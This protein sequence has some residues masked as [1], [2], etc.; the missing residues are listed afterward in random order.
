MVFFQNQY[1]CFLFGFYTQENFKKILKKLKS[2]GSKN[3][4]SSN[5]QLKHPKLF[6]VLLS[7]VVEHK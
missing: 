1:A 5:V 3:G 7:Q 4:F 6:D 2:R